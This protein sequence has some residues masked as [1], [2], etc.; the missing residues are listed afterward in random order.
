MKL[1][2]KAAMALAASCTVQLA[3]AQG[4]DEALQ[5]FLV[6]NPHVAGVIAAVQ[7]P[8]A[9][10]DWTGAAGLAERAAQ[11]PAR[12]TEAFRIAS[13]TKLLVA[14]TVIRLD[15]DGALN[16]D[17]PIGRLISDNTRNQLSSAGYDSDAILVRHLI[18]HTSGL[19]DFATT[20]TFFEAVSSNTQRRWTR[21]E[22]IEIGMRDGPPL[23][24][25]GEVFSYSDTGY[26]IAGEII[27]RL[28]REPLGQSV[29]AVLGLNRLAL[30][31][32]WWELDEPEPRPQPLYFHSAYEQI[33][34]RGDDPSY[35]LFGGG[36]MV[37]TT[38]D[39]TKLLRFLFLGE[40]FRERRTLAAALAVPPAQ[41]TG[42]PESFSH[43][44]MVAT[45][46]GELCWGHTG[47]FGTFAFY[48][49]RSDAS[50]VVHHG[51]A[52]RPRVNAAELLNG[53]AAARRAA[54]RP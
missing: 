21:S 8:R 14:A 9:G 11:R 37:S 4:F 52:G 1:S 41:Q 47:F 53:L 16:L 50:Y 26:I 45:V 10:I 39:L 51:Q 46:G 27:E 32:T 44:G 24:R 2:I 33:D 49:P 12:G 18:S 43:M 6:A 48:C 42:R 35:D 36:G 34:T 7:A 17:A 3:Q 30:R 25:P 54:T 29:R 23:G 38:D 22:Q 31:S 28:R 5:R 19:R 40:A 20:K 13:V 15:E